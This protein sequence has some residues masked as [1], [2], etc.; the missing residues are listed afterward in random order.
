MGSRGAWKLARVVVD[1]PNG[2]PWS[3][4][5]GA[6]RLQ[7]WRAGV[8]RGGDTPFMSMGAGRASSPSRV[9]NRRNG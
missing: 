5:G 6:G 8:M 3:G 2:S 4:A 1:R 9:L 7:V